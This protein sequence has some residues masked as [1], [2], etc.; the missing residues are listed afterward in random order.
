M[1]QREGF[2]PLSEGQQRPAGL[3]PL[4]LLPPHRRRLPSARRRPRPAAPQCEGAEDMLCQAC[5]GDRPS[6]CLDCR[7]QLHEGD[8]GA[9]LYAT[10]E[11]KCVPVSA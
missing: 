5:V 3:E 9:A 6:M 10:K 2:W 11:G 7:G 1:N 8:P 4:A